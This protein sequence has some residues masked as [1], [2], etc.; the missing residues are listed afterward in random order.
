MRSA[1]LPSP[2]PPLHLLPP[3]PAHICVFVMNRLSAPCPSELRAASD[4]SW[5]QERAVTVTLVT[6]LRLIISG[7]AIMM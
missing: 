2:D 6:P 3:R 7:R 5:H 1:L 4:V